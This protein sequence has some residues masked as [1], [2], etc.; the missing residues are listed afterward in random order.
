MAINMD[1]L[2]KPREYTQLQQPSKCIYW[3]NAL[4]INRVCALKEKFELIETYAESDH[5]SHYLLKCREC[6]QLYFQE[7]QEQTDWVNSNDPQYTVYVP[8][9]SVEQGGKVR[10]LCRQYLPRLHVDFPSDAPQP[11]VY[12]AAS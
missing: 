5:F 12:W 9:E 4:E 10:R 11:I 6:G 8:V 3:K 7:F 2:D 1:I